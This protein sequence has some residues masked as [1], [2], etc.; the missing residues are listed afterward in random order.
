MTRPNGSSPNSL[1]E[2]RR[3]SL[4][5][6]LVDAVVQ[7][8]A[9]A[10]PPL[11]DQ[12]VECFNAVWLEVDGDELPGRSDQRRQRGT[13]AGGDP[14][15]DEVLSGEALEDL[16]VP[17]DPAGMLLDREQPTAGVLK[18]ATK[19]DVADA[20]VWSRARTATD[21]TATTVSASAVS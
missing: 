18:P 16:E 9:L 3:Q 13:P 17:R 5:V 12:L 8:N 4:T 6:R 11:R 15:L 10:E 2:D 21:E 7:P 20:E 1:V 19:L 14:Q